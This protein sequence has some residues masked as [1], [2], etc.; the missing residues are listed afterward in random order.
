MGFWEEFTRDENHDGIPDW[1]QPR[2]IYGW[3]K[4]QEKELVRKQHNYE[5]SILGNKGYNPPKPVIPIPGGLAPRVNTVSPTPSK[6]KKVVKVVTPTTQKIKIATSQLF[7]DGESNI[8]PQ[9]MVQRTFEDIGG[10]EL[11]ELTRTDSVNGIEQRYQPIAGLANI[12][13][14]YN[15]KGLISLQ[16]TSK[17]YF[18]Q[19]QILLEPHIPTTGTGPIGEIVYFNND[20]T[21]VNYGNLIINLINLKNDERLEVEFLT[22]DNVQ[23]DTII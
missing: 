22:F 10:M 1:T 9:L 2:E 8:S 11:L 15:T 23:D 5:K 12:N 17:N 6:H 18:S 7:I 14:E 19:F 4:F 16:S 13:N 20:K 3:K 21:D